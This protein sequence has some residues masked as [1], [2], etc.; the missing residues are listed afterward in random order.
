[1]LSGLSYGPFSFQ[2]VNPLN[3]VLTETERTNNCFI[4]LLEAGPS[5]R[6]PRVLQRVCVQCVDEGEDVMMMMIMKTI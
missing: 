6:L 5:I 1:M 2:T 3:R 4:A